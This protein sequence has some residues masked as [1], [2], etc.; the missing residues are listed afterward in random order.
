MQ[1]SEDGA[2]LGQTVKNSVRAFVSAS[3]KGAGAGWR[4]ERSFGNILSNEK[5]PGRDAGPSLLEKGTR[6]RS[7]SRRDRSAVAAEA[8]I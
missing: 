4:S 1:L 2:G 6:T 7:V 5:R 3:F 8:I